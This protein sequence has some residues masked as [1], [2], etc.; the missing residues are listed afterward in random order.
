MLPITQRAQRTKPALIMRTRGA[1]PLR[2]NVLIH[3][4]IAVLAKSMA[5]EIIALGHAPQVVFVQKLAGLALFAETA[6]PVLADEAVEGRLHMVLVR[7]GV[8]ERAVALEE[9]FAEGPGGGETEAVF[10]G[11]EW[12]ECEGV[13]GVR[14][15]WRTEG[16]FLRAGVALDGDGHGGDGE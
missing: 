1:F 4:L 5:R 12:R 14:W 15:G 6:H 13:V 7:A 2:R 10:A 8:A 3:A 9:R 11:E 16:G